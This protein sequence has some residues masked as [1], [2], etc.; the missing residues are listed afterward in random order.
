MPCGCGG[1]G[2]RQAKQQGRGL[3]IGSWLRCGQG[4]ISGAQAPFKM[5]INICIDGSENSRIFLTQFGCSPTYTWT[6]PQTP[7][8]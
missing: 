1:L 3:F 8:P 2:P 7:C 5:D 6:C 4:Y